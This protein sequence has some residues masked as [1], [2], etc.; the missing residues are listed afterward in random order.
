MSS[1]CE[2]ILWASRSGLSDRT[3][4]STDPEASLGSIFLART[5]HAIACDLARFGFPTSLGL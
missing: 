3:S 1:R 4:S 2:A 5:G